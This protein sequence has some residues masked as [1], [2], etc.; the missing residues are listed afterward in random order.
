MLSVET[1]P[2]ARAGPFNEKEPTETPNVEPI[3]GAGAAFVEAT[4]PAELARP[5]AAVSLATRPKVVATA[6]G[7]AVW[8]NPWL[9]TVRALKTLKTLSMLV[10]ARPVAVERGILQGADGRARVG[11]ARALVGDQ[12]GHQEVGHRRSQPGH[13]VVAGIGGVAVAAAGD[14][15]CNRSGAG[16]RGPAGSR[17]GWRCSGWPAPAAARPWLTRASRPA[18]AGADRLVPPTTSNGLSVP[19]LYGSAIQAPVAGSATSETSGVVR[20]PVDW[21]P[22]W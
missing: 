15:R 11:R 8:P 12:V 20:L 19:R 14:R 13:Q 9:E 3:E 6:T 7:L 10:A 1:V 22:C 4:V 21:T 5:G 2:A 18:Q 16:C 17:S